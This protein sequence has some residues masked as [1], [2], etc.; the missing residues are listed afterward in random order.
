MK[1]SSTLLL[2]ALFVLFGSYMMLTSLTKYPD[3]WDQVSVGMLRDRANAVLEPAGWQR[4]NGGY[5]IEQ[6]SWLRLWRIDVNFTNNT[7]GNV[8]IYS[9][10]P[11]Q[12]FYEELKYLSAE[13]RL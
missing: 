8:H 9:Q 5:M 7:I 2:G 6:R 3:K 11:H 13:L 10:D 4:E 12:Y 1:L